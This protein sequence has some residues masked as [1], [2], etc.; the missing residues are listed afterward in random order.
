[1]HRGY[2][3][4]L[5]VNQNPI[6][7]ECLLD[8]MLVCPTCNLNFY[9]SFFSPSILSITIWVFLCSIWGSKP[10]L[11]IKWHICMRV[12]LVGDF[13]EADTWRIMDL[14]VGKACL[15]FTL[16]FCHI[17]LYMPTMRDVFELW[18][19]SWWF[20][21]VSY[22]INCKLYCNKFITIYG[23]KKGITIHME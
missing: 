3:I 2:G 7:N 14:L 23:E 15:W 9:F 1:M 5:T 10:C 11:M 16:A 17:G 22:S 18:L 21:S 12:L 19:M 20:N 6:Y 8:V 4:L 13:K